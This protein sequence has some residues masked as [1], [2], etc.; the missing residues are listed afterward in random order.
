MSTRLM[1]LSLLVV[2]C[3]EA[4]VNNQ[5]PLPTGDFA[6]VTT[7]GGFGAGGAVNTIRLSDMMVVQGL[8]TTIDQDN[9]VRI[10]NGKAYVLNRGPGTLR[11][12]D[13]KTWKSPVEIPTGDATA[14]H[15]MSNPL[16][17][18]VIPGSSKLYV[19]TSGNDAAHALGI[20]DTNDTSGVIKWIELPVAAADA[21]GMPGA[22]YL[23]GCG[24]KAYALM[25]DYDYTTFQPVG[26]SRIAVIDTATDKFESFIT[27]SAQSP[28]AI[29]ATS[30]DCNE[31]LVAQSGPFGVLPDGKGGIERVNLSQKKSLGMLLSDTQ[32]DGRPN[33]I[34]I[35]SSSVAFA[36]IYFDPQPDPGSGML[37]LSSTKVIAFNPTSGAIL[38]D[39]L[40]K[41]LYVAFTAVTPNNLIAIGVDSYPGGLGDG[42]LP[43]GLYVG[44]ADGK[45]ISETPIDLG[46]NPYA[47]SFQ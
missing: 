47:I 17:V 25:G 9:Q 15:A 41:S 1:F 39:V 31:V 12:Y 35:A 27:L 3:S 7:S 10:V 4:P 23:Y 29:V 28:T 24:G 8:D 13:I 37:I 40:G 36:S 42:K 34:T 5:P 18:L 21:D 38:G 26:S 30:S 2:G 6:V 33:T 22:G 45:A 16:D 14:P 44:K 43:S 11:I 20:I 19:T 32:L 46:Q